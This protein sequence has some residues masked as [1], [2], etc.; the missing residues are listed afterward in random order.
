MHRNHIPFISSAIGL[1]LS[2]I[3]GA[4]IQPDPRRDTTEK[5]DTHIQQQQPA[6]RTNT[7]ADRTVMS[8]D[9]DA[10]AID[11][12]MSD[13]L[14]QI[15]QDPQQ[16]GDRLFALHAGVSNQW[17]IQLSQL[18]AEKAQDLKVKE[19][20]QKIAQEHQDNFKQL[21][22]VAQQL[23]VNLPTQLSSEKQ[24]KLAIFRALP[25]DKLE[26]SYLAKMKAG[27]AEAITSFADHKQLTK[28]EDL[29]TYISE[30]LPHLKKHGSEILS[31]AS[32]KGLS[33]DYEGLSSSNDNDRKP[34]RVEGGRGDNNGLGTQGAVDPR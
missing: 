28:N 11:R 26:Q 31:V 6:D 22:P 5:S 30:S 8:S 21:Q 25:A 4:Q 20:A 12:Q 32:T 9:Q 16:A 17:E 29:K 34:T 23:S 27:H 2:G 24:Q 19:L 7:S 33:N 15:A 18:V 14:R 3:V 1:V 13:T 10:A